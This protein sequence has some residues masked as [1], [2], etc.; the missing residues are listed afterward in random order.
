MY[1]NV[2]KVVDNNVNNSSRGRVTLESNQKK[3]DQY[4]VSREKL[5]AKTWD[6]HVYMWINLWKSKIHKWKK[7]FFKKYLYEEAKRFIL[8]KQWRSTQEAEGVALEMR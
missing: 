6:E 3:L 1:I 7:I 8:D 2:K 5:D 4:L